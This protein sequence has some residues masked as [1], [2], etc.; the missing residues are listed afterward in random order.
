MS[1][2]T[3]AKSGVLVTARRCLAHA[4]ALVLDSFGAV[5]GFFYYKKYAA[6]TR[7]LG[8]RPHTLSR[9]DTPGLVVL[10]IDGLSYDHLQQA[11]ARHQVPRLQRI[12]QRGGFVVTRWRCGLPSSTPA[13]QAGILFGRNENIPSF[14]WYDKA[15]RSS[16]VCKLPGSA[17]ELQRTIAA[18]SEGLLSGGS[19]YVNIFDG[20]AS[21][22]I[23][24]LSSLQPHRIFES[25][26]GVGLLVLFLL[27]PFRTLRILYLVLKEYVTDALQRLSSR[28][29]GRE[30]VPFVGVAPLLRIFGNVVFREIVTFGVLVDIYRGVPAIYATYYGY[31]E[32]AHHFGLDSL[33]ARQALREVDHSI[34]EIDR[35]RRLNLSRPYWLVVLSDHGLTPSEPFEHRYGQSLGQFIA[36][37]LGPSVLLSEQ[38]DG[39]HQYLAQVHFLLEELRAIERNLPPRTSRVAR[40]VRILVQRRL[41][42]GGQPWMEWN[43]MYKDDVVVRDSGSLSHVYFNLSQRPL[44]LSEIGAAFPQLV[45]KLLAHDGIWLVVAREGEQTLI[46]GRDGLLIVEKDGSWRVEGENPL[47][48][49]PEPE[50]AA[51]QIRRIANFPCSGDLILF[52]DYDPQANR[53]ICFE[54]QWAAHGGLG[55]PQ[56]YPFVLYPREFGWDLGQVR[57]AADVYPLLAQQRGITR[58]GEWTS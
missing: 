9:V 56:D 2:Q 34:G 51:E 33:A 48:K 49:L 36:E 38:A 26:R 35:L 5:T 46:M 13:A 21:S 15:R 18:G 12:L 23:F 6:I 1:D 7:R 32:L 27:N 20:D 39:E 50:H 53:V 41:R 16:V 24:T 11:L 31:D 44:D 14:R 55:G 42:R 40:R 28:L 52:G 29:R 10:Q 4:V 43:R 25:V 47:R 54:R 30:F 58:D 57:N 45:M 3:V 37:Q 17:A 19:S 8:V 22:A